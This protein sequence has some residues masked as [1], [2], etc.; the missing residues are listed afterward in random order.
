MYVVFAKVTDFCKNHID[1]KIV[2][3]YIYRVW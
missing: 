3:W 2:F 1:F